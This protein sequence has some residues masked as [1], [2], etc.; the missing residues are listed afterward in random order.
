MYISGNVKINDVHMD[1]VYITMSSNYCIIRVHSARRACHKK[2]IQC[3]TFGLTGA[4]VH[5][6]VIKCIL[7]ACSDFKA[8]EAKPMLFIAHKS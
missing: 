3:Y 4:L 2:L 7:V 1:D 8:S 5:T 6:L